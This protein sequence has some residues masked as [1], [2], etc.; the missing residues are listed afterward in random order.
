MIKNESHDLPIISYKE[1]LYYINLKKRYLEKKEERRN[2][3][4]RKE[5]NDRCNTASLFD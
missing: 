3:R 4:I 5:W 2:E 1:K